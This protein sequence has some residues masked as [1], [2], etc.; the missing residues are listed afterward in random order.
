MK[1]KIV[2]VG[3]MVLV[4]GVLF[5]TVVVWVAAIGA[6]KGPSSDLQAAEP[7]S[8]T[9]ST[10]PTSQEQQRSPE[11][12]S[13]TSEGGRATAI[14]ESVVFSSGSKV[15]V[16]SYSSPVDP[17]NDFSKPEAGTQFATIDVEGCAGDQPEDEVSLNPYYFSLQ[18]PD[19]ARLRPTASVV[20]P[21]L[22]STTLLPED[23]VRGLVTFQVPQG[24]RPDYVRFEQPLPSE[25][26]KWSLD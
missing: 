20:E 25:V 16:H 10:P 13:K 24:Q 2:L 7:S 23:C 12:S 11:A 19:N 18:M 17:D 15:T 21:A 9:P 3:G 6:A 14:G 5:A 4:L 8:E 22:P 1:N 26:A